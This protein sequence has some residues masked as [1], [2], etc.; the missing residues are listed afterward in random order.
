MSAIRISYRG[1]ARIICNTMRM[2][3][4]DK[5]G[6]S[7]KR[8]S[9]WPTTQ[10]I[11]VV[12]ICA[13]TLRC[14]KKFVINLDAEKTFTNGKSLK[15][16]VFCHYIKIYSQKHLVHLYKLLIFVNQEIYSYSKSY[17]NYFWREFRFTS[18]NYHWFRLEWF[19]TSRRKRV[20][21]ITDA[22]ILIW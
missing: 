18:I 10:I 21:P 6:N 11:H 16:K 1:W 22:V 4:H 5:I 2:Q 17:W 20:I 12:C 13:S 19:C 9:T 14:R 3:T 7:T 15:W 8:T